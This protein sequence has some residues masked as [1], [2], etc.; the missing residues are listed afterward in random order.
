[1]V[2]N[3]MAKLAR[4]VQWLYL[5]NAMLI[6]KILPPFLNY[7]RYNFYDQNNFYIPEMYLR[8]IHPL[9]FA[10]HTTI[11]DI[12][13]YCT[14]QY[15]TD[16]DNIQ[17]HCVSCY[18]SSVTRSNKWPTPYVSDISI[19]HEVRQELYGR[20]SNTLN[21]QAVKVVNITSYHHLSVLTGTL[22]H[23][24]H[25][26]KKKSVGLHLEHVSSNPL[27]LLVRAI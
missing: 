6:A 10:W 22:V 23:R 3:V 14:A 26:H 19:R 13:K 5:L 24:V 18:T 27:K 15:I 9:D 21:V 7:V 2:V 12:N 4:K 20:S 1:M 8:S 25:L 16:M 17:L 11:H